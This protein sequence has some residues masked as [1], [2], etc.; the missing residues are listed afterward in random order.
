MIAI[1]ISYVEWVV[2]Y[3]PL[4]NVVGVFIARLWWHF[5][6]CGYC[7]PAKYEEYYE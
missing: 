3:L 2:D 1:I 6:Y 4:P 5:H 7:V